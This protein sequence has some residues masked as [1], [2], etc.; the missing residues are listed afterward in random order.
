MCRA[1]V[2]LVS[3]AVACFTALCRILERQRWSAQE[4]TLLCA[5][6]AGFRGHG[7]SWSGH[8]AKEREAAVVGTSA[9]YEVYGLHSREQML[10]SVAEEDEQ[11]RGFVIGG[12]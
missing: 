5:E 3:I 11:R 1:V 12:N 6:V 9:S 10:W 2:L 8:S 4:E 7:E